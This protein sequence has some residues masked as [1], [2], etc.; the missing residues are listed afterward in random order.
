M[1]MMSIGKDGHYVQ[2]LGKDGHNADIV[3]TCIK[4]YV[5]ICKYSVRSRQ[6]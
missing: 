1:V 4:L 5:H 2:V 6:V 3:H